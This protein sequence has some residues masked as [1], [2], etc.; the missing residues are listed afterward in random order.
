MTTLY[1]I[2]HEISAGAAVINQN[3]NQTWWIIIIHVVC[4]WVQQAATELEDS[5][6]IFTL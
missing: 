1:H 6:F 2:Q 4:T 5:S 3:E